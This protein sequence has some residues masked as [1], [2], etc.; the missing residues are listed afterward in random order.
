M[1]YLV[2]L[3]ADAGQE[4]SGL[5]SGGGS[6]S[7]GRSS[8]SSS[9]P[10][11]CSNQRCQP[12]QQQTTGLCRC[13]ESPCCSQVREVSAQ[14]FSE[15]LLF[16]LLFRAVRAVLLT[17][18]PPRPAPCVVFRRFCDD[19]FEAEEASLRWRCLP[20]LKS[21][22]CCRAGHGKAMGAAS[23][24]LQCSHIPE[25]KSV[26][27]SRLSWEILLTPPWDQPEE[28]DGLQGPSQPKTFR[29]LWKF[30]DLVQAVWLGAQ[31]GPRECLVPH[32]G[33]KWKLVW[34]LP[35]ERCS[36]L[37]CRQTG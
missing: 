21:L 22:C 27:V 28:R 9:C 29:I 37:N 26:R 12:R 3:A 7:A 33:K 24:F 8:G 14:L 36:G 1:I 10:P 31:E 35:V 4:L 6:P 2:Y 34:A 15:K 16:L 17:A 11:V 25:K 13:A 23:I 18:E 5:G 20:A 32:L 30:T 19:L